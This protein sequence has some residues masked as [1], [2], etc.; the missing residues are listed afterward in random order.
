MIA[1]GVPVVSPSKTPDRISGASG[2]LRCVT[3]LLWP[4]RR[5]GEIDKLDGF[6][7]TSQFKPTGTVERIRYHSDSREIRV[8]GLNGSIEWFLHP[9]LA[10]IRYYD[11]HLSV[12]E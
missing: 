9:V 6:V 7:V 1:I 2:S 5:C 12:R 8:C 10:I 3:I 11:I 4:G